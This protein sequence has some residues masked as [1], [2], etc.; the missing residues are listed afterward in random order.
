MEARVGKNLGG[1]VKDS[2]RIFH[3]DW[4]QDLLRSVAA[5]MHWPH[6]SIKRLTVLD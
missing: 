1:E 4:E 3:T 2:N 5:K 6:F